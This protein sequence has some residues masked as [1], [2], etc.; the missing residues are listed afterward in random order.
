MSQCISCKGFNIVLEPCFE[1]LLAYLRC[2][3]QDLDWDFED[4]HSPCV[5]GRPTNIPK[6]M[7][8][9]LLDPDVVVS[10]VDSLNENG[11][12]IIFLLEEQTDMASAK[13]DVYKEE[14]EFFIVHKRQMYSLVAL[15]NKHK[16]EVHEAD[17]RLKDLQEH[18]IIRELGIKDQQ[19]LK[20]LLEGKISFAKYF[21]NNKELSLMFAPRIPKKCIQRSS[22]T[23]PFFSCVP[24]FSC[25]RN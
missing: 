12:C 1:I 23:I 4:V 19:N 14:V 22:E 2:D 11:K 17:M 5:E 21:Q 25:N 10:I 3:T 15:E 9:M 18:H 20:Y 16:V 24:L 6:L 13:V 8:F 7:P